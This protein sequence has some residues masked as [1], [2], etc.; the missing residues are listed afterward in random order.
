MIYCNKKWQYFYIII[1]CYYNSSLRFS[2]WDHASIGNILPSTYMPSVSSACGHWLTQC[3]LSFLVVVSIIK[4]RLWF[5]YSTDITCNIKSAFPNCIKTPS[6]QYFVA[7]LLIPRLCDV[8]FLNVTL[9]S[10]HSNFSDWYVVWEQTGTCFNRT[11][12]AFI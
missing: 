2:Q 8:S 4:I 9:K 3:Y 10:Q 6:W 1:S 11:A 12:H 5:F 7:C